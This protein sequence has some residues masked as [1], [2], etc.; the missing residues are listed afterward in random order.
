V[1]SS[2]RCSRWPAAEGWNPGLHDAVA[3]HEGDPGAF[4][5][6]FVGEKLTEAPPSQPARAAG[7]SYVIRSGIDANAD[8]VLAAAQRAAGRGVAVSFR[9]AA[10]ADAGVDPELSGFDVVYARCLVSHLPDPAAG[11]SSI[12]GAATPGGAIL[13]EDVDVAAVW[14]SPRCEALARH[15]QLYVDAAFGLGAR[16]DV[17]AD[18]AGLLTGLGATDVEVDLVQP[19]LR[20]ADDLQIHARTME[21]IAGPVV[22]QGLATRA[23]VDDL[24]A[25]L[26][27]WAAT[28]GTVATLP[29]I[30]QVAARAPVT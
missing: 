4:L 21:A 9:A 14:S 1:R 19:V 24:V 18:L 28:P 22:E 15:A 2:G 20:R 30:V 17:G 8:V 27:E 23:E 13:V 11:L 3:F 5:G 10:V 25:R 16:P 29:R 6:L 12:L 26:D 7:A